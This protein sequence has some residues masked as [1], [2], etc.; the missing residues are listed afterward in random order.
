MCSEET[1]EADRAGS[2]R[3]RTCANFT[4]SKG[5][6]R[7]CFRQDTGFRIPDTAFRMSCRG[8]WLRR[9]RFFKNV[10]NYCCIIQI[11]ILILQ[12]EVPGLAKK[13]HLPHFPQKPKCIIQ[14]KD[15]CGAFC[16]FFQFPLPRLYS[17]KP[18]L[19]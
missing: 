5:S 7:G 14:L 19:A 16:L 18:H 13:I 4:G 6:A 2:G 15:P 10:N 17:F 1:E 8:I 3:R 12:H 9:L 11:L